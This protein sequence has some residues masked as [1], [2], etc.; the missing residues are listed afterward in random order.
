[1]APVRKSLKPAVGGVR[2]GLAGHF[3]AQRDDPATMGIWQ[4]GRFEPSYPMRRL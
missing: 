1:M 4:G 2:G 3:G